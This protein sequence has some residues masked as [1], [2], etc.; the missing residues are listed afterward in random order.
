MSEYL[1]TFVCNNHMH[2]DFIAYTF[3]TDIHQH[4]QVPHKCTHY[5][6]QS[7]KSAAKDIYMETALNIL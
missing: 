6:F 5:S 1:Y 3:C 4:D 2:Y 7:K